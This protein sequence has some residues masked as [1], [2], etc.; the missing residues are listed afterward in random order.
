MAPR[1]SSAWGL[2]DGVC[3][4]ERPLS[5]CAT[6]GFAP[7][8]PHGLAGLVRRTPERLANLPENDSHPYFHAEPARA[9]Q[10]VR[11]ALQKPA[12]Y[13]APRCAGPAASAE[14]AERC[15]LLP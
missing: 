15:L 5:H 12:D 11:Y 8:V 6:E 14:R 1:Q 7:R 3:S 4:R 10:A 2:V 13:G 9:L